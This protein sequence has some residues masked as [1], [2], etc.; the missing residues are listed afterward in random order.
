MR[1]VISERASACARDTLES[2]GTKQRSTSTY[3][4]SQPRK[5]ASNQVSKLATTRVRVMK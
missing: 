2:R 1:P 5:G 3:S 4:V